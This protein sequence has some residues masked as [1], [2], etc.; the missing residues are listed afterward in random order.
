[1]IRSPLAPTAGFQLLWL[2]S[3][4][5]LASGAAACDPRGSDIATDHVLADAPVYGAGLPLRGTSATTRAVWVARETTHVSMN[6]LIRIPVQPDALGALS[7]FVLIDDVIL[8]TRKSG[9]ARLVLLDQTGAILDSALL[10][11][12]EL[13]PGA[14]VTSVTL[15]SD[16]RTALVHE[17]YSQVVYVFRVDDAL[18]LRRERQVSLQ[19]RGALRTPLLIGTSIFAAGLLDSGSLV[20]FSDAGIALRTVMP[21]WHA[22][23]TIAMEVRRHLN[24]GRTGQRLGFGDVV[25]AF[26]SAPVFLLGDTAG[27]IASV[28]EVPTT[29]RFTFPIPYTDPA[30]TER[31][32]LTGESLSGFLDVAT[33][34][35]AA[36]LLYSGE[37]YENGRSVF[38]TASRVLVASWNADVG[39]ELHLPL[40]ARAIAADPRDSTLVVYD[41][42]SRAL[43]RVALPGPTLR[44]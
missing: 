23:D 12:R 28:H 7:D 21:Q 4:V 27:N 35:G 26:L 43:Y 16:R 10:I 13:G 44:H 22:R 38:S 42:A 39:Y 18:R 6:A 30:G 3:C 41:D 8:A 11:G 2:S 34:R 25:I 36:Y 15:T 9:A 5:L 20:Q 31:F 33:T 29:P 17:F 1:M 32:I 37:A 19:H 40:R 24:L 14:A